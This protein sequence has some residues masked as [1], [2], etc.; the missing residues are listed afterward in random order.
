MQSTRERII[1]IMREEHGDIV[2][3]KA[4]GGTDIFAAH[5]SAWHAGYLDS[6]DR[7]ELVMRLEDEFKIELPDAIV[8]DVRNIDE[9][10][11]IVDAKISPPLHG[12]G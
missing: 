7:M 10:A 4:T 5:G 9:L 8:I 3:E 6:L 12:A 11:H 2:A 1:E